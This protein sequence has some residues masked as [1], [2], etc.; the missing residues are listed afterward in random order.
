MPFSSM[1]P[2]LAV[3]TQGE[4]RPE[5]TLA[6]VGA[7]LLRSLDALGEASRLD[8]AVGRMQR[9][10]QGLPLG[11]YRDVLHGL[12][13]GHPL[14]PV[15]VQ[16]PM[17]A[18]MSASV[19]DAVPGTGRA[20]R[21]LVGVG[22]VAA[23]P[24]SL[25]GWVD[26]AEQHEQQMRTGLVHAVANIAGVGLYTASWVARGRDRQALGKSLGLAGLLAVSAGGMLGGHLAYRQ[27]A[28]ANKAEPVAH[29]LSPDWQP[30]GRME[31]FPVGR[32]VRRELGEVP[33]LV[34]R[35]AGGEIHVLADRCSHAS[36]PLSE[37]TV[38]DG[39]VEC[40]WHGSVF[41]LS[42]GWNV[43]GPATAPQPSF[44]AR[45]REDGTVEVRLPG[46][47]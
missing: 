43:R 29:L 44:H 17:G 6:R 26:W 7:S 3:L 30:V 18:W 28:G 47:G 1:S 40:P 15:L 22:V 10:V 38:Q 19:L 37:G 42:D 14:H 27:A 25:A 24:A 23:G 31:D 46:A 5:G 35:Q 21:V 36:G 34:V 45:V 32:A 2:K 39:C 4:G 16:V 9:V 13:L 41:R 33:L 20:A 8:A 12:P 11:R